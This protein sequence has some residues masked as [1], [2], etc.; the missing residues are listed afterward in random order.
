MELIYG[1][2]EF[3]QGGP[4]NF[5]VVVVIAESRG[6]WCLLL[7]YFTKPGPVASVRGDR[8]FVSFQGI[9]LAGHP[10][11]LAGAFGEFALKLVGV[12]PISQGISTRRHRKTRGS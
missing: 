8:K 9:R 5:V 10:Q 3:V 6:S 1:V 12:P 2:A 4:A 7:R 11:S